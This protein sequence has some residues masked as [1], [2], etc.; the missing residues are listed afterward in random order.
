MTHI[1]PVGDSR[2]H[3]A[4]GCWCRARTEITP[5]RILVIHNAADGRE[6]IEA[7][8]GPIAGKPWRVVTERW[9]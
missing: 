5:G 8:E 4:V 9:A 7:A 6:E 1:L 2:Y 3:L